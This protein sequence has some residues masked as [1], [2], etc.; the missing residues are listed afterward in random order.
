MQ[1]LEARDLKMWNEVVLTTGDHV[2]LARDA[3]PTETGKVELLWRIVGRSYDPGEVD[4]ITE[5]A[6]RLVRVADT[7]ESY[8]H[9]LELQ[10]HAALRKAGV[11]HR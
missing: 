3:R 7:N 9:R 8:R 11:S 4:V 2:I 10:H 6:G 1:H 5:R